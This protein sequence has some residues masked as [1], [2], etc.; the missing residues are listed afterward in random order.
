MQRLPHPLAIAYTPP[1]TAVLPRRA[2]LLACL[3]VAASAV[4]LEPPSGVLALPDPAIDGARRGPRCGGAAVLIAPG[5]ALTLEEALPADRGRLTVAIAGRRVPAQVVR[6]GPATGA[7]LLRFAPPAEAAAAPLVPADS[8]QV[9]VGDTAWTAGNSFGVLEQDGVAAVSRGIVSGVYP[10]PPDAPPVRGRGGRILSAYRGMVFESDA[11]INDG[12]QGGA[13]LDGAG[14]LIG[15]VS[16]GLARERRLGTAV[17]IHLVLADL[18]LA[19]PKAAP[20]GRSDPVRAALAARAGELA[21]SVALVYLERPEGLGNPRPTPRPAPITDATPLY[22]RERLEGLWDR[23]YHEQQV[24]YTDQPVTALAI[25][26]EHLLTAASNLHGGARRGR[27]LIDGG[28]PI[29][30]ELVAVHR[31]LDLAVLR[32]AQPLPLAPAALAERPD[33]ASGDPVAILGRHRPGAGHTLTAGVVSATRRRQETSGAFAFHQTDAKANYGNL[34]GPVIEPGG[35]V[36][37]VLVK[38]GPSDGWPWLIN[39]GVALFVDSATILSVLPDLKAGQGEQRARRLQLGV[40]LQPLKRP[41]RLLEVGTVLPGS[42]AEAA[43]VRP[44]DLLLAIEGRAITTIDDLTRV[45]QRRNAGDRV[46]LRLRRGAEELTVQVELR[47]L[48]PKPKPDAEDE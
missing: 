22:D 34:G 31:P 44:A 33:L 14:R 40:V 45:L 46:A 24:F 48:D 2:A 38:L 26:R 29:D 47:L 36:V 21:R 11:A 41:P 39:S 9:Q 4:A 25:D 23:Y 37:G 16:L 8:A 35:A 7:V 5:E 43:G 27:V 32:A 15:L 13:L 18:G 19:A 10:I 1:E 28:A 6:T 42:G 20:A 12:N 3:L 30:C 17:P